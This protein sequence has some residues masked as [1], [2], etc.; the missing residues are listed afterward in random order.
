MVPQIHFECLLPNLGWKQNLYGV[1]EG[2]N[3]KKLV[4]KVR[5]LEDTAQTPSLGQ[6]TLFPCLPQP[7]QSQPQVAPTID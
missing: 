7:K 4:L 2:S 5:V 3:Y 1:G 6:A